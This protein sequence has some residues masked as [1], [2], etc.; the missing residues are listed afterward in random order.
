[1]EGR[2]GG[3]VCD[4]TLMDLNADE[5]RARSN[6]VPV[7]RW[8]ADWSRSS[9]PSPTSSLASLNEALREPL[10]PR[11]PPQAR[12]PDAFTTRVP[13]FFDSLTRSTLP[14][15]SLSPHPPSLASPPAVLT[16]NRTSID[17]L[18]TLTERDHTRSTP[19]PDTAISWWWSDNQANVDSLLNEDD[20]ADSPQQQ[21][22]NIRKKC[23][24]SS[25]FCLSP[26]TPLQT[27]PPRTLLSFA[28]A[29]SVSIPSSLVLQLLL[30]KSPIGAAS[31]KSFEPT[32]PR[33]S[34]HA[35]PPQAAP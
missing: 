17:T 33:S 31:A 7:L 24:F 28:M 8:L 4:V 30:Y 25:S 2:A 3:M 22:D 23:M 20:R 32:A 29:Y 16:P 9:T 27:T 26:P 10:L 18:R 19:P 6:H 21:Q 5:M 12:L 1:M 15:S 11:P 13:P 34:L 14:T 35:S